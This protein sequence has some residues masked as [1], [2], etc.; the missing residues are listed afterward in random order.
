MRTTRRA[1]PLKRLKSKE[2]DE[3]ITGLVIAERPGDA[4]VVVAFEGVIINPADGL[5][6]NA[7]AYLCKR[8][9]SVNAL[10]TLKK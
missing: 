9:W 7:D 6:W 4:H 5:V 10:L 3:P 1:A 8:A 2:L